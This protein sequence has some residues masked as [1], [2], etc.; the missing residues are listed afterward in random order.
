[1]IYELALNAV[2][3]AGRF[4]ILLLFFITIGRP[5]P[6]KSCISVKCNKVNA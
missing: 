3:L 1:M 5:A 4:P 2:I 6:L